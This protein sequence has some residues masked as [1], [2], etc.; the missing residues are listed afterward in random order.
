MSDQEQ[1]HL[2]ITRHEP[3]RYVQAYSVVHIAID[4]QKT[5]L[6]TV[7]TKREAESLANRMAVR[8]GVPVLGQGGGGAYKAFRRREYKRRQL[9]VSRRAAQ[10]PTA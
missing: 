9:C 8:M 10:K 4:G 2:Q 7:A 1:P 5:R 3:R 6:G